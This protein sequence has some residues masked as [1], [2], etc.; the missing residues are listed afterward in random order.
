[1]SEI[2][3][4]K[5]LELCKGLDSVEEKLEALFLYVRDGIKF[6]FL[7]KIDNYKPEDI[8]GFGIGQCNNKS[9]LFHALCRAAGFKSL[10]HFSGITKDIQRGLFRG[11]TYKLMPDEISHSWVEVEIHG[12]WIK[13]DSFINDLPFYSAGKRTLEENGWRTGYSIACESGNSSAD[14]DLSG[15]YFVQ[16]DAITDSYGTYDDPEEFFRSRYY[17]N[18]PSLLKRLIYLISLNSINRRVREIRS[19][20]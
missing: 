2:V 14:F 3:K 7:P 12:T 15:K 17:S 4:H 18:R 16:M 20:Y 1:M 6:G 5:Q 13:M 11:L 10:I 9:M 19:R 8:I